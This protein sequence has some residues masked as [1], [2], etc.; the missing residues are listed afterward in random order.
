MAFG[1]MEEVAVA[2]DKRNIKTRSVQPTPG[3]NGS[4]TTVRG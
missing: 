4:V 3:L 1:P 2:G